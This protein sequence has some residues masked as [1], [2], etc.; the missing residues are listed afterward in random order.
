MRSNSRPHLGDAL[1]AVDASHFF[2]QLPL[3]ARAGVGTHVPRGRCRDL[4]YGR[5]LLLRLPHLGCVGFFPWRFFLR[6]FLVARVRLFAL[7]LF[8]L[9]LLILRSLGTRVARPT[10]ALLPLTAPSLLQEEAPRLRYILSSDPDAANGSLTLC[11]HY[12][13]ARNIDLLCSVFVD[14]F[15]VVLFY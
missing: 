9:L 3:A 4:A 11:A 6:F 1:C 8:F 14:L 5:L 10:D 7:P 12:N 2:R 15:L 13:L